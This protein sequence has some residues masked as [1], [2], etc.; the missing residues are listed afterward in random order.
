M[1]GVSKSVKNYFLLINFTFCFQ[2]PNAPSGNAAKTGRGGGGLQ[3][4]FILYI[5][6]FMRLTVVKIIT[7]NTFIKECFTYIY[8]L[9]Q[10]WST[11]S[12]IL[13]NNKNYPYT[14]LI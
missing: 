6:S 5:S 14:N 3:L 2:K 9:E 8:Y 1:C 10:L 11:Y 12:N 4:A 13:L 7:K